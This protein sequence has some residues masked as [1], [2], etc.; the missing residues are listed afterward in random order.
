MAKHKSALTLLEEHERFA[1]VVADIA[2]TSP[3][4]RTREQS[5]LLSLAM[6]SEDAAKAM[7]LG[8]LIHFDAFRIS[9]KW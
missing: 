8:E 3:T 7:W 4:N 9:G 5:D 1:T 2:A 6:E